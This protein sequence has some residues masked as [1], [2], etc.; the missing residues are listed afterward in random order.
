MGQNALA[1]EIAFDDARSPE[2][3]IWYTA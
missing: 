3:T 2:G 1:D